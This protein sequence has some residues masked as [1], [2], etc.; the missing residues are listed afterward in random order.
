MFGG[1]H[2]GDA[3]ASLKRGTKKTRPLKRS[4][5]RHMGTRLEMLSIHYSKSLKMIVLPD[6]AVFFI[7]KMTCCH[8]TCH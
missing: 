5:R 4:I 3:A 2:L 8:Y 7:D 6:A 1:W